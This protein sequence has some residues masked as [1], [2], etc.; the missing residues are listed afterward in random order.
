[1]L[2]LMRWAARFC[3]PSPGDVQAFADPAK[4]R[5]F[6]AAALVAGEVWSR[7]VF[8]DR[9]ALD[10]D[11][12]AARRHALGPFRKAIEESNVPPH[13]G[14]SMGRSRSLFTEHMP[15]ALPDF[16]DLFREQTGL[17][18]VDYAIA[19]SALSKYTIAGGAEGPF[20]DLRTVAAQTEFKE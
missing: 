2:E 16:D 3:D 9:V 12:A 8:A 10:Q 18:F 14:I 19:A 6:L 15:A 5:R 4:R 20:F 1:M 7:S 17:S 11:L 13:L